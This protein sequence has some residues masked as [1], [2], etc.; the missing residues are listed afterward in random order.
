MKVYQNLPKFRYQSKLSTWIATIA[1]NTCINH[2]QKKRAL[3]YDDVTPDEKTL[4][5]VSADVQ[6]PDKI[7]ED[8]DISGRLQ[9]EIERLDVRYRSI[10]TLYHLH[11]M[12]YAEI[13]RIMKLPEGTVKSYLF[14]ARKALRTRLILQYEREEL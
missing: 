11:G 5:N 2:L 12:S 7:T 9:E 14:R 8:M 6:R 1:Y 10:L 13:G 3:L 4:D